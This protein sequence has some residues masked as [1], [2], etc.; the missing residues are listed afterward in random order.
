[1][2]SFKFC[3]ATFARLSYAFVTYAQ[4]FHDHINQL[5]STQASHVEAMCKDF[6]M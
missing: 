3:D 1:M 2:K 6:M 4:H 5:V